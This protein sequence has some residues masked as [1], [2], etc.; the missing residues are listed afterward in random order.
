[1][2]TV[3]EVEAIGSGEGLV[4]VNS[5]TQIEEFDYKSGE[6]FLNAPLI[7]DFLMKGWLGSL[8]PDNQERVT[9]EIANLIN[10]ERHSAEFSL[11]VKATLITGKKG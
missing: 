1:L 7:S 9:Q 6:D 4:D 10:E 5:W 11:T 3:S 8:A 2:P